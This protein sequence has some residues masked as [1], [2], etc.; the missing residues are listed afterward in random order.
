MSEPTMI[1]VAG[2][3]VTINLAHWEGDGKPVLAIHGITANCRCWDLLA[4]ALTPDVDVFAM[5][6]RGRGHSDK[7]DSGYSLDHHVNDILGIMKSLNL[8]TLSLIGHSLGAFITLVFAARHPDMVD[9]IVLVDGGGDLSQEQF[10]KVFKGI[11]PAF[12]RLT[13]T[14]PDAEAY[15]AKMKSA[16]Y[17]QPWN[18]TIEAYY[19]YEIE[20]CPE[21]VRT[22]I[23]LEHI[24]EEAANVRKVDCRPF[25]SQVT[26][27][28][29]IL[30]ANL[31][32][33]SQD[34]ILLP[35]DVIERM[36]A[37]IPD[38]TRF[39]VEGTNH[40]GIVLQPHAGRDQALKSF[41][42]R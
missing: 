17:M 1:Q 24:Q 11:K 25:Y 13:M 30:R 2:D 42:H 19:R 14:F 35:P 18:E 34:D 39:E 27:K 12:D 33:L 41:L 5:D 32:L 10:D 31:G 37:E 8:E 26:C 22:N 16:P 29:L 20:Q 23:A 6:L 28:T 38:V 7:P 21:G 15:L 36:M 9:R 40:Y 3:G 4:N